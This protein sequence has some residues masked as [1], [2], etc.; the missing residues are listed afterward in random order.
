[1]PVNECVE[2]ELTPAVGLASSTAFSILQAHALLRSDS[3]D[4]GLRSFLVCRTDG[5]VGYRSVVGQVYD[6]AY[7]RLTWSHNFEGAQ[8]RETAGP[9]LHESNT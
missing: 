1:M 9:H 8:Y 6:E 3:S 4:P 7:E 5:I 2:K